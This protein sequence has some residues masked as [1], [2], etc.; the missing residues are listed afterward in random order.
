MRT[1]ADGGGAGLW[2][3]CPCGRFS[4][5]A[6]DYVMARHGA[7]GP[8]AAFDYLRKHKLLCPD[9]KS[10]DRT[11]YAVEAE[12]RALVD[13][14]VAK[15]SAAMDVHPMPP[16][17]ARLLRDYGAAT[18]PSGLKWKNTF[19]RFYGFVTREDLA[20]ISETLVANTDSFLAVPMYDLP[21]RAVGLYLLGS[22][23]KTGVL[24]MYADGRRGLGFIWGGAARHRYAVACRDPFRAMQVVSRW[25]LAGTKL[26]IPLVL[27]DSLSDVR[28]AWQTVMAD[29]LVFWGK[30]DIETVTQAWEIPG[31]KVMD[32]PL[33]GPAY[34]YSPHGLLFDVFSRARP[35][36]D[37]IKREILRRTPLAQ[38]IAA[39][40]KGN[41]AFCRLVMERCSTKEE[42]ASVGSYMESTDVVRGSAA[43]T[44]ST[45]DRVW[46][47]S[48]GYWAAPKGSDAKTR[49]T[50]FTVS[51]VVRATD[52]S[53]EYAYA[54]LSIGRRDIPFKSK[55]A[56]FSFMQEIERQAKA[57]TTEIPQVFRR[58]WRPRI[59]PLCAEVAGVRTMPGLSR[60][61][62]DAHRARYAFPGF[63]I[64]D[65]Q[66]GASDYHVDP[67]D[68]HPGAGLAFP[69]KPEL[70]EPPAS[71]S[72]WTLVALLASRFHDQRDGRPLLPIACLSAPGNRAVAELA[73]ALRMHEYPVDVVLGA[74]F[75]AANPHALPLLVT[76]A[77]RQPLSPINFRKLVGH[78]YFLV[79][80]P[81]AL[82][83]LPAA[84]N[85]AGFSFV[86]AP[87]DDEGGP[88]AARCLAGLLLAALCHAP[89]AGARGAASGFS[90]LRKA[91]VAA[92]LA[93]P[94]ALVRA[95]AACR[96][97]G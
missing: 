73:Y 33:C 95:E 10:E 63:S 54:T 89:E 83:R 40:F 2:F 27:W 69:E 32:A 47:M 7:S 61:G 77:D 78:G 49:V 38:E 4:G 88:D 18:G 84:A 53:G 93:V 86:S 20:P 80:L 81:A 94:D 71:P 75:P 15:A 39:R 60:V 11:T 25:V 31:A 50:N 12:G 57:V 58:G 26:D 5:D 34:G 17:P 22:S 68:R 85:P 55:W 36:V 97:A 76:V 41:A 6:V 91:L 21:G 44:S 37:A 14:I 42:T 64:V 29:E 9:F 19:G 24:D 51:N 82:S 3:H 52:A 87:V 30:L 23:R 96:G 62:W 90:S 66:P 45:G 48:D 43:V 8:T 46:A 1:Y 65:G 28:P 35:A 13:R 56:P 16:A 72:M 59:L 67:I 74:R 70:P 92:R 79:V